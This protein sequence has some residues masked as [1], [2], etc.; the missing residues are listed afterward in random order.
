[1]TLIK[2]ITAVAILVAATATAEERDITPAEQAG[3]CAGNSLA[4][5]RI[6]DSQG[7]GKMMRAAIDYQQHLNR[8]WH[9][10]PGFL[11]AAQYS[12][13]AKLSTQ[14]RVNVAINCLKDKEPGQTG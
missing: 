14:E 4:I 5:A 2:T 13:R 6:A 7:D 11:T 12:Y 9:N 10:E 8:K 1:M 3:L